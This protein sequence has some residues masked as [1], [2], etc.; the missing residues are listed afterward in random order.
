VI[1]NIPNQDQFLLAVLDDNKYFVNNYDE[2][3]ESIQQKT[4]NLTQ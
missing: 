1:E 4:K 3:L 2:V